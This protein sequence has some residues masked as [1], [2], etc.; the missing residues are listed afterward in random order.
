MTQTN[1]QRTETHTDTQPPA[2]GGALARANLSAAQQVL[3]AAPHET[4]RRARASRAHVHQT[5]VRGWLLL[6]R[7]PFSLSLLSCA[8]SQLAREE[9]EREKALH[10]TTGALTTAPS[11]GSG[12]A[13]GGMLMK[14][15]QR[16]EKTLTW[17]AR[18][19]CQLSSR[20]PFDVRRTQSNLLLLLLAPT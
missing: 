5:E 12:S 3:A 10:R 19:S 2:A 6:C 4:T 15:P 13:V 18:R 8:F 16:R 9:R 20:R 7:A 11:F 1:T 17:A 14:Q